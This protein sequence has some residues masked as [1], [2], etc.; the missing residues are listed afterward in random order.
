LLSS[1]LEMF[2]NPSGMF[3]QFRRASC[4]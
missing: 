1:L 4:D 2:S 3:G